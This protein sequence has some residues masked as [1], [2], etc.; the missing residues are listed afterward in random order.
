[1]GFEPIEKSTEICLTATRGLVYFRCGLHQEGRRY[2]LAA[3]E[4]AK[5][6]NSY[7][8]NWLA[9]LNYA[10]E[11]ILINSDRVDSVMDIVAKIPESTT[12][13]DIKKLK[14]EVVELYAKSKL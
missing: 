12:E 10:R 14:N 8:F 11:E 7:Y 2:Y 1:L 6:I 3:I 4:E 5:A 9:I 13:Y